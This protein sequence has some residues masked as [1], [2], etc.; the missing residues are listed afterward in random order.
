MRWGRRSRWSLLLLGTDSL[1]GLWIGTRSIRRCGN[2]CRRG[3][4]R[5]AGDARAI[6]CGRGSGG[7][8]VRWRSRRCRG[9]ATW[10]LAEPPGM[11]LADARAELVRRF[12]RVFGPAT[13]TQLASWAQ[14]A[15][16]HA[17]KLF[18]GVKDELAPAAVEG[19]RGVRVGGRISIGSR[20]RRP[21]SGVR[22]LGGHDPYVSAARPRTLVPDA[23]PGSSSSRR[24]A[25]RASCSRTAAGGPVARP[26]EGRR[27]RGG[28]RVARRAGRR[29]RGGGRDRHVPRVWR[30]ARDLSR[31]WLGSL[32]SL[33]R[34]PSNGG[35]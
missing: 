5:G 28:R 9:K 32:P 26:Q 20:L 12:L 7:L 24:S 14:T 27:P 3:C 4:C 25:G 10:A 21:A 23:A 34:E 29:R 33:R 31:G 16:S 15:P 13:H 11:S 30:D 18:E 35:W 6:T 1:R 19:R 22:L 2:G 17:K 8:W